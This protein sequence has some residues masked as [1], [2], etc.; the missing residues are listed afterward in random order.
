MK[1]T[2]G[3]Q[4]QQPAVSSSSRGGASKEKHSEP[5]PPKKR[6]RPNTP[7]YLEAAP[8]SLKPP[9]STGLLPSTTGA[10]NVLGNKSSS[11][12]DGVVSIPSSLTSTDPEAMPSPTETIAIDKNL[13]GTSAISPGPVTIIKK[14]LTVDELRAQAAAFAEQVVVP[15]IAHVKLE[16]IDIDEETEII[17]IPADDAMAGQRKQRQD[18]S[19]NEGNA[20][21][22]NVPGN[23]NQENANPDQSRNSIPYES[24]GFRI[25]QEVIADCNRGQDSISEDTNMSEEE[26]ARA[27][28]QVL[29]SLHNAIDDVRA[30]LIHLTRLRFH[31]RAPVTMSVLGFMVDTLTNFVANYMNPQEPVNH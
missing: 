30:E 9:N 10:G 20:E 29:T 28:T 6:V 13:P 12:E 8:H 16:E 21:N 5:L 23:Q 19:P 2:E 31:Q 4:Q 25:Q 11:D 24:L 3:Q 17:D 7:S 26:N 22:Q 27:T 15:S 18:I 14:N 1:A